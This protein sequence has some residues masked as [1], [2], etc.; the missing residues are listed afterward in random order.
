[1]ASRDANGHVAAKHYRAANASCQ[2]AAIALNPHEARLKSRI[3][4]WRTNS[5]SR[6]A[7][8]YSAGDLPSTRAKRRAGSSAEVRASIA[9]ADSHVIARK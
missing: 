2:P 7:V 5:L 4:S 9:A 6:S 8:R 1:M 3:A